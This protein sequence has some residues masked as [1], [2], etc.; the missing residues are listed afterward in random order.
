MDDMIL[1]LGHRDVFIHWPVMGLL[2]LLL[3]LLGSLITFGFSINV[4]ASSCFA[5]LLV[6]R[7]LFFL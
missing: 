6:G 4:V 1:L 3:F 2:P 7:F 5:H